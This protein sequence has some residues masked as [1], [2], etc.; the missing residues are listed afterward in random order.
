MLGYS[1]EEL[2]ELGP[3]DV[4]PGS[5]GQ[6]ETL[7]DTLIESGQLAESTEIARRKDG[8]ALA[9]EV[10]R[11]AQRSESD[12]VIVGVLRDITERTEARNRLLRSATTIGPTITRP[13]ITR[14]TIT[15][16]LPD[17]LS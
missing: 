12:W 11:H 8:S 7:Y 5:R 4:A 1:R 6:L 16:T 9:V 14:P 10:H 15:R 2:L 13:T 17:S 3:M